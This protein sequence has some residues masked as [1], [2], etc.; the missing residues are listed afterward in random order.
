M[1][2]ALSRTDYDVA[3]WSNPDVSFRQYW[4]GWIGFEGC[5]VCVDD[6]MQ[7]TPGSDLSKLAVQ[8]H[9]RVRF[10]VG[11]IFQPSSKV[12]VHGEGCFASKIG[13]TNAVYG[14]IIPATAP[15]DP[16]FWLLHSNADR[17]WHRWQERH[18]DAYRPVAGGPYP[19]NLDD[20]LEV[21]ARYTKFNTVCS[22]QDIRRL[23]YRYA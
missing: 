22:V 14:T 16:L 2:T 8:N 1:H 17:V 23:G 18:P 20:K 19:Q 3:P 13:L 6:I 9:N 21:L 15:N 5:G 12:K 10:Y 4:E 7:P 11:G